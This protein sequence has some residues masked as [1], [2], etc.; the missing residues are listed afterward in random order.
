MAKHTPPFRSRRRFFGHL[1]GLATIASAS[2]SPKILAETQTA[3]RVGFL[4][5]YPPFSFVGR[6][7]HLHG[8]DFEVV[9]QLA[10]SLGM[11]LHP[12]AGTGNSI[13]A[14]ALLPRLVDQTLLRLP[15]P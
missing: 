12:H 13:T 10:Q 5:N 2:Y 9:S 4:T 11:K 3:W 8:F 7:K 14:S 1:L 15:T 6:D